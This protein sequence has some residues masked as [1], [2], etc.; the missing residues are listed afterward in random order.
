MK[1]FVFYSSSSL[2]A[3]YVLGALL[4]NATGQ[5]SRGGC[6]ALAVLY[7][8]IAYSSSRE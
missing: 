6:L 3:F 7:G 8:V 2:A 1:R 5:P 4:L